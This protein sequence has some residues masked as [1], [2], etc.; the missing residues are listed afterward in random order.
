MNSY[1]LLECG[2]VKLLPIQFNSS[3]DVWVA[4]QGTIVNGKKQ[5]SPKSSS[6]WRNVTL[7]PR[8]IKICQDEL[9]SHPKRQQFLFVSE[10]G[11]YLG[12]TVLN[13]WLHKAKNE[14]NITAYFPSYP[15]L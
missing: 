6:S 1:T 10:R 12:N 7:P 5:P 4:I 11:K 14:L 15:H 9:L 13:N 2:M 3:G 8:A